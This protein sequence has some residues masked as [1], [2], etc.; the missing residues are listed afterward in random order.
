[1]CTRS[2]FVKERQL[3]IGDMEPIVVERVVQEIKKIHE[4]KRQVYF[5]PMG[6]G[7]PLLYEGLFELFERIKK[8]S[9]KIKIVLVTNGILLNENFAK[10][11][12]SLEIDEVCVSLNANDPGSYR[13]HMGTDG[14]NAV[15]RNIENLI[16]LRNKNKQVTPSVFV[17]YIDYDQDP[18]GFDTDI[19]MWLKIMS[20]NDKCFIH[21]VVNQAGFFSGGDD[22]GKKTDRFP[23]TQPLWRI[24]IKRNGDIFPCDSSLYSGPHIIRSL[25]LGNIKNDSPFELFVLNNQ[26]VLSIVQKMRFDDY[27]NLPECQHC[28]TCKL[29][30]NC[31][32]LI[33]KFLRFSG[34]KWL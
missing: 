25:Y 10:K 32:F 15:C 5:V 19:K 2:S 26:K 18:G 7:E 29:S 13:R 9:K 24:A 22:F 1:M 23:C 8:I 28:N 14:Y 3:T 12:I 20:D 21:P 33:P 4:A 11:I 31:Y 17:Q 6:L 27:S 16:C 30:V 34:E